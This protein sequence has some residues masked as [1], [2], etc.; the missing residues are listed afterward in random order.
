MVLIFLVNRLLIVLIDFNDI[1][2]YF[3]EHLLIARQTVKI[4]SHHQN[5][6]TYWIGL[7][8]RMHLGSLSVDFYKLCMATLTT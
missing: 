1:E 5:Y 7:I 2:R 6:E 8:G 3:Y 4:I